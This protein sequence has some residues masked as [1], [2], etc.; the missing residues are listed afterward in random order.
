ML[1]GPMI[2]KK[3][4]IL[5]PKEAAQIDQLWNEEYPI[6]I[7][8]RFGLLL[9]GVENY[10]HYIIEDSDKN[11]IAWAVDFEK[12]NETRFSVIVKSGH[13]GKG[14]G[15]LLIAKLQAEIDEFY[16]WEIDHD[17]DLKVNGE[18][19]F[20]PMPFYIKHGFSIL[21]DKRIESEMLSATKV[22]WVSKK[23]KN[24]FNKKIFF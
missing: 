15:S 3:L 18:N 16:G 2:I 19:Y 5:T 21:S 17:N 7:N 23:E 22:K 13:Q 14:L 11:I 1:F 10:H 9:E 12:D 8:N 6:K 20:S 4:K 24:R